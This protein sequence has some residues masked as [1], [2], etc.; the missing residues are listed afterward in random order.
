MIWQVVGTAGDGY[1]GEPSPHTPNEK[2][3]GSTIL[4]ALRVS[5]TGHRPK[6]RSEDQNGRLVVEVA[7]LTQGLDVSGPCY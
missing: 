2:F 5:T 3:E 1:N 7:D 4:K 6:W